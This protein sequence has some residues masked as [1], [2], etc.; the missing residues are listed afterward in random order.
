MYNIYKGIALIFVALLFMGCESVTELFNAG[1]TITRHDEQIVILEE[2]L[3]NVKEDLS[4]LQAEYLKL[5]F[6]K[7]IRDL[8]KVALLRPGDSGYSLVRFD[9]GVLTVRL[10]DVS[11][12]AN[13]SKIL[14]KIGNIL[15]CDI[16]E[17]KVNIEWGQVDEEGNPNNDTSKSKEFSFSEKLQSGSWTNVSV[18]LDDTPPADLG[19]VRLRD[20][21]H[22][23]ISLSK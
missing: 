16:T 20:V 7:W 18:V 17:L 15:A 3:K 1:E 14:L 23:G 11:S 4:N 13:S 8:D 10:A 5:L 2:E 21:S 6:D 12:F 22:G 9:L 19:F